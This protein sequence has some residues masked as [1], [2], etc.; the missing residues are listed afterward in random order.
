MDN[1]IKFKIW[2]KET[3][4]L[5]NVSS[6]I[7]FDNLCNYIYF[8]ESVEKSVSSCESTILQYVNINDTETNEEIYEGYYIKITIDNKH[9]E[10]GIIRYSDNGVLSLQVNPISSKTP[11]YSNVM[12]ELDLSSD[13]LNVKY[14][15]LGNIYENP[16]LE[17]ELKFND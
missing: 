2:D 7:C 11:C 17:K 14:E 6:I 13:Y 3:N 1:K 5:C 9:I 8:S 10:K 4:K 15:I 12:S 16:E